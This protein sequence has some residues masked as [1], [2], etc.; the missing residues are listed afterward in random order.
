MS[1]LTHSVLRHACSDAQGRRS[2]Y[3]STGALLATIFGLFTFATLLCVLW[4]ILPRRN[5]GI[6]IEE[7]DGAA[8]DDPV[9]SRLKSTYA[10][11]PRS[12]PYT[13]ATSNPFAAEPVPPRRTMAQQAETY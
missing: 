7:R 1:A 4:S 8:I 10:T 2:F 5:V 11:T 6:D 3:T 9:R 13:S 12:R